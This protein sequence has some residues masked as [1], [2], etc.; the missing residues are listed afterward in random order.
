MAKGG[1]TERPESM[2]NTV[3]IESEQARSAT[4]IDTVPH[5]TEC[6]TRH[7]SASRHTENGM[8]FGYAPANAGSGKCSVTA[9]PWP[10]ALSNAIVPP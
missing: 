9:V 3:F 8:R 7:A 6:T 5:D 1:E 10:T 4:H 2:A